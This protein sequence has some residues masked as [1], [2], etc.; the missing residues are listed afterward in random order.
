MLIFLMCILVGFVAHYA[1][2]FVTAS[3]AASYD[4][5]EDFVS[6]MLNFVYMGSAMVLVIHLFFG[7][8]SVLFTAFAIGLFF[9]MT[10]VDLEA[11]HEIM[12]NIED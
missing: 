12:R 2:I 5:F 7:S 10:R 4:H 1:A 3:L 11:T 8:S 6:G 9:T